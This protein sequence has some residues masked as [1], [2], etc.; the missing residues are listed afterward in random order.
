MF[1]CWMCNSIKM[2]GGIYKNA[3]YY[4]I[5]IRD[6]MSECSTCYIIKMGG[7]VHLNAV[8]MLLLN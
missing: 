3:I 6:F 1:E 4:I 8:Y 5:E 7:C 2:R